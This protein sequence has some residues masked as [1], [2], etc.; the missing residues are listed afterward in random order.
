[1]QTADEQR[2]IPTCIILYIITFS[3]EYRDR[4]R[5]GGRERKRFTFV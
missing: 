3:L 5:G 2:A 4:E 1:M